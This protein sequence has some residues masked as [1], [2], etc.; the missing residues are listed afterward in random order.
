ML[1]HHSRHPLPRLLHP[2]PHWR[3]WPSR[4]FSQVYQAYFPMAP[5]GSAVVS[6]RGE[7]RHL[8]DLLGSCL[9]LIGRHTA[10]FQHLWSRSRSFSHWPHHWRAF[11][12]LAKEIAADRVD[13][14]VVL[15]RQLLYIILW[16]ILMTVS[17]WSISFIVRYTTPF[18]AT[19]VIL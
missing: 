2:L 8:Y 16:M 7:L 5:H 19:P 11:V 6:Q 10:T 9:W 3:C 12:K 17:F 14:K 13:I 15:D 18:S 1:L 4:Q